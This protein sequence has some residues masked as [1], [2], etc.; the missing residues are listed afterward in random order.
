[1]K[2]LISISSFND[3]PAPLQNTAAGRLLAYHNLGHAFQ[4]HDRP[5][6]LIVMCMDYRASLRTP[7]NFAYVIRAAGARVRQRDFSVSY[8][9]GVG[10]VTSI[11]VIAHTDCGMINVAT[12]EG[13]FVR[14]LTENGGWELEAAQTHFRSSAASYEIGSETESAVKGAE[15]LREIY[16]KTTV[17]PFIYRVEDRL[18]YLPKQWK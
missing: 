9:I 14:G 12:K 3:I 18:L 8:A 15:R 5:E 11:A 10:G 7:D 13:E 16:K 4:H 17:I 6:L 1:L 2:D